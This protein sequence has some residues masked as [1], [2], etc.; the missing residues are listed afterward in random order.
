M[1]Q[2]G[3]QTSITEEELSKNGVFYVVRAEMYK[4]DSL[5]HRVSCQKNWESLWSWQSND[6]GDI[7]RKELGC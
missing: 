3:K 7:S 2:R 5:K 1:Q 6:W 4:Q